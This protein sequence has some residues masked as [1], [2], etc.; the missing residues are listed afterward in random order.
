MQKGNDNNKEEYEKCMII[1]NEIKKEDAS[2][3]DGTTKPACFYGFF[4]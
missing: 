4:I 3:L 1:V 2:V